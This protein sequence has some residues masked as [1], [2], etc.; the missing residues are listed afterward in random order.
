M[1]YWAR[2]KPGAVL[3]NIICYS[4]FPLTVSVEMIIVSLLHQ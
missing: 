4:S 2:H 1:G 3:S